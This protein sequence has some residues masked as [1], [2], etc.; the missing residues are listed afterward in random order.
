MD[1]TGM[2]IYRLPAFLLCLLSCSESGGDMSMSAE[3]YGEMGMPD[4]SVNW[5][6]DDYE[7]VCVILNNLKS[8]EPLSLPRKDSDKSSVV[9]N[10]MINPE[11]LSFL[12]S[13]TLSLQT[14]AFMIQ[15]YV[16]IQ[17]CLVTAYTENNT[18]KQYY[19]R[20]LIDLYIFGL[21]IAQ[22]M[23]DL[24]QMINESVREEDIE[25]QYAYR[26]IQELYV[27][28]VKSVLK[29]QQR[30]QL[31]LKKDLERLSDFVYNSVLINSEWMGNAAAE[32][33][34]REAENVIQNTSSGVIREK[35]DA[36]IDLLQSV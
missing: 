18:E 23:L 4:Y 7:D 2:K 35:Y 16:D 29:N 10:R 5:S 15:K 19:H 1:V 27:V 6:Y 9:F 21:T 28:M 24:G 33:I 22:D 8:A 31:F 25:M 32:E 30:S 17:G 26:S 3:E 14:K 36:L 12:L 34:I 20:E 11:N 13:D